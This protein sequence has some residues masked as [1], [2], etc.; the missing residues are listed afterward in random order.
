MEV[1]KGFRNR[2]LGGPANHRPGPA[3]ILPGIRQSR[4][5]AA[6]EPGPEPGQN[7]IQTRPRPGP[8]PYPEPDPEP[9]PELGP[10]RHD[11]NGG[12]R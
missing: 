3:V 4:G 2:P 11:L 1:K 8:E 9:D 12:V 5:G 6:P 10:K 7:R